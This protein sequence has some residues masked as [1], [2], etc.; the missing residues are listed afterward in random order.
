MCLLSAGHYSN[1]VQLLFAAVC[2]CAVTL[3]AACVGLLFAGLCLVATSAL[4]LV[5]CLCLTAL[6]LLVAVSAALCRFL[7][8]LL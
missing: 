8:C 5:T 4:R 1:K 2:R 3:F 6:V 7:L